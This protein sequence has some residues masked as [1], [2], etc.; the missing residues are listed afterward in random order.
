MTHLR[1]TKPSGAG[2]EGRGLGGGPGPK[3]RGWVEGRGV[4][5]VKGLDVNLK[6]KT[7]PATFLRRSKCLSEAL[8]APHPAVL[9]SIQFLCIT[10][11]VIS[12]SHWLELSFQPIIPKHMKHPVS[13]SHLCVLK[14]SYSLSRNWQIHC[15]NNTSHKLPEN[16]C[17]VTHG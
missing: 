3:V 7:L 6:R 15:F 12:C 16:A 8:T 17:D 13:V 9:H 2:G 1:R 10:D 4:R 14:A 5:G 11:R